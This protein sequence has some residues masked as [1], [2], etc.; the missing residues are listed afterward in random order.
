MK[1]AP[2]V[3]Q[4]IIKKCHECPWHKGVEYDP[5]V[6]AVDGEPVCVCN[7]GLVPIDNRGESTGELIHIGTYDP[8]NR[9]VCCRWLHGNQ[10]PVHGRKPFPDWCPLQDVNQVDATGH[11]GEMSFPPDDAFQKPIKRKQRKLD[12]SVNP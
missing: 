10:K 2:I 1:P 11:Y 3:K 8:N 4:L 7:H 5:K 9:P 12:G 6:G